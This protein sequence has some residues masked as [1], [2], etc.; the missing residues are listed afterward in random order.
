[1]AA[2]GFCSI[3]PRMP[4]GKDANMRIRDQRLRMIER[5]PTQVTQGCPDPVR[6]RL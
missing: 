5:N 4:P 1:M 6:A 3:I 2:V